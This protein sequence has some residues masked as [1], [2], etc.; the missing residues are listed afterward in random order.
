MRKSVCFFIL[1]ALT[2][3]STASAQPMKSLF[4]GKNLKNW[5]IFIGTALK[6][7]DDL[8]LKAT[9]ESTFSVVEKDGEK[10]IRVSGDVNASLAT[11]KEY[12]NY[13]LRLEY[14]WGEAVYTSRNSGLLY[15][16]YGPFGAGIGTW[17]S[18]IELQLMHENLGDAYMMAD[19]YAEISVS[20][21]GQNKVFDK[22]GKS[23]A[24]GND[25]NGGKMARKQQH[26]EKPLGEWNVVDL[27]CLGNTAIHVVNG[28]K[29]ME[30]RNTG[31]LGNGTVVPLSKG[32]IQLQSEGGEF[33]IRNIQLEKINRLPSN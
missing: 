18:S 24:F 31:K 16:S 11:K 14:R 7:F 22:A 9:P 30:C 33:F 6:G 5:D 20:E 8:K 17:M 1:L 26:A 27:Y 29:V 10:L 4:N 23:L 2:I 28:V 32:K 25:Q 12:E 21:V 13:H 15:H 3:G 19:T